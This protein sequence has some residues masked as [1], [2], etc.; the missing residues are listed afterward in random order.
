M[1]GVLKWQ[2]I[3][4]TGKTSVHHDSANS[5]VETKETMFENNGARSFVESI[6]KTKVP[7]P[8]S[9]SRASQALLS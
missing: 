8:V 9:L 2:A 6:W 4:E 1:V 5:A 7:F 3:L